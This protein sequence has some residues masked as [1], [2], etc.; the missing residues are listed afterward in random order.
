MMWICLITKSVM[1]STG[2]ARCRAVARRTMGVTGAPR[3]IDVKPADGTPPLE[4]AAL[5]NGPTGAQCDLILMKPSLPAHL[6]N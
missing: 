3:D 2:A 4:F 1:S 6:Q 5:P